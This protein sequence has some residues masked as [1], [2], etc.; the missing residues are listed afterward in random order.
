MIPGE[1][2]DLLQHALQKLQPGIWYVVDDINGFNPSFRRAISLSPFLY[3]NLLQLS[4][5]L[6]PYGDD[7]RFN[8]RNLDNIRVTLQENITVNT[9]RCFLERGGRNLLFLCI[10]APLFCSPRDQIKSRQR[11]NLQDNQLDGPYLAVLNQLSNRQA[12]E[13]NLIEDPPMLVEAVEEV[14]VAAAEEEGLVQVA[15]EEDNEGH[16]QLPPYQLTFFYR[17]NRVRFE[18]RLNEW[19]RQYKEEQLLIFEQEQQRQYEVAIVLGEQH[20]RHLPANEAVNERDN[21][22]II[23]N[24]D[25]KEGNNNNI[26]INEDIGDDDDNIIIN[27]NDDDDDDNII[28]NNDDDDDE[29]VDNNNIINNNDDDD[30]GRDE[31]IIIDV[32]VPP[33]VNCHL[34]P[35]AEEGEAEDNVEEFRH[36]QRQ[37][38]RQQQINH[39]VDNVPDDNEPVMVD[40][41]NGVEEDELVVEQ[42]EEEALE[43]EIEDERHHIINYAINLPVEA[44]ALAGHRQRRNEDGLVVMHDKK[45]IFIA[46]LGHWHASMQLTLWAGRKILLGERRSK[47]LLLH[48]H[49]CA[50]TWDTRRLQENLG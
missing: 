35:A 15:G 2:A 48:A 10:D 37:Q 50:T 11:L 22:N 30:V 8:M 16:E 46:Q 40:A 28:I 7:Y 27:N 14:A 42:Q 18:E 34:I 38:Q 44:T 39:Q 5:I 6:T 17:D 20:Q 43:Q 19:D 32:P 26:I 41:A 12:P 1:V 4:R 21:N 24:V 49:W 36:R 13:P 3:N 33:P 47:L 23:M 9:S 31:E 29:G 25:D 45:T